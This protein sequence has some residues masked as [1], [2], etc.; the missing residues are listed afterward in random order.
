[1]AQSPFFS[2]SRLAAGRTRCNGTV[3]LNQNLIQ[4][5]RRSFTVPCRYYG[6]TPECAGLHAAAARSD[7]PI[8]ENSQ[9][10]SREA[11]ATVSASCAHRSPVFVRRFVS[12]AVAAKENPSQ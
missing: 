3:P 2:A 11:I 1:M 8:V 5:R 12:S 6:R 4:S 7:H 10:G 9:R